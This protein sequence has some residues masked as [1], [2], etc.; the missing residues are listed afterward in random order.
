MAAHPFSQ[1]AGVIHLASLLADTP[2][3]D[4]AILDTLP[5][6]VVQAL[7]LNRD[8]MK[9]KFPSHASFSMEP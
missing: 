1:L 4:P 2:S 7:Q 5:Q 9:A 3:D 6:D 8:W